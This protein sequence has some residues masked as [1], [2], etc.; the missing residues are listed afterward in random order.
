MSCECSICYENIV[1]AETGE[2]KLTCSHSFHFA[3]IAK[4]FSSQEKGSCPNCRKE[5]SDKEDFAPLVSDEEDEGDDEDDDDDESEGERVISL[6]QSEL[7]TLIQSYNYGD[8]R[9]YDTQWEAMCDAFADAEP[10][11]PNETRIEFSFSELNY[12]LATHV[13]QTLTQDTWATLLEREET[14]T[15]GAFESAKLDFSR[16]LQLPLHLVPY[17]PIRTTWSLQEDGT[18]ER[19]VFGEEELSPALTTA[20]SEAIETE[21]ATKVQ[22]TW[23]G[24]YTRFRNV[25]P[26]DLTM[27]SFASGS[28]VTRNFIHTSRAWTT[29][30][31]SASR[32]PYFVRNG[33]VVRTTSFFSR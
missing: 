32:M 16:P 15:T 19:T 31:T 20:V 25:V 17:T 6:N 2:V 26:S 27:P 12:F 22:A 30:S 33:H 7:N 9:V 21:A 10:N 23:R 28:S 13:W 3:C 14:P 5:V 24:F 4:W 1:S 29:T 11:F 18:W 8:H